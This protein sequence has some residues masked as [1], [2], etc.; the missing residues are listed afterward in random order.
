MADLFMDFK[1]INVTLA[2]MMK[3][4]IDGRVDCKTAGR[5]VVQLQT[6]SKL[7]RVLHRKGR[8]GRKE[9]QIL[10]QICADERRL[11][12]TKRTTD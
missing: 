10:P 4:V 9:N 1:G 3:A 7:L 12:T 6:V 5:L 8:E 2:V 11:R